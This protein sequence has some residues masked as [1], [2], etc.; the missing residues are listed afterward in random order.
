MSEQQANNEETRYEFCMRLL[1]GIHEERLTD[2]PMNDLAFAYQQGHEAALEAA[3]N[4][5]RKEL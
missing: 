3:L 1:R 2:T 5:I 4:V